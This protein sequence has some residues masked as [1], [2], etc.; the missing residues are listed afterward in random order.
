MAIH[1][2][3]ATSGRSA[4]RHL[5]D[6]RLE[7][8]E[9]FDVIDPATGAPFATAPA[10]TRDQLD[11][12]VA[13]AR[14]AQP[15]WAKAGWATRAA[16][17]CAFADAI[18]AEAGELERLLVREQG[19][20][21]A[22]ARMEITRTVAILRYV[23]G[24]TLGPEVLRDDERGRAE[25][26]W[27][28][29][30][31]VGAIT[32][33]NAPVV[34]AAPKIA[35]ALIAG[36][37]LIL[38]PSPYTPLTTLRLAEIAQK[39]FPPGVLNVLAGGDA[40]GRWMTEHPGI[41]KITF[42]GSVATGKKVMASAA[43]TLK[44]L[45]LELG[46]NDAAI[47]L[48]DADVD[49][50]APKLFQAAFVNSGQ[51]C[52]AVK[53]V[54]VHDRLYEPM[55]QALA[56]RARDAVVGSGLDPQTTLGPVQ[57]RMQYERVLG[58]LEDTS[59]RAGPRF[60]TGGG[61]LDRPGYFIAPPIVADIAE[62][63][64]LVDEEAFGPALPVLRFQEIDEAITRANATHFGLGGSIWTSDVARGADL[65]GRL[66]TGVAWVNHH[67]GVGPDLPFG[68]VKESGMGRIGSEMGLK[69][70]LEPQLLVLP[71]A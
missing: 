71:P 60:V 39:L 2:G 55:V 44:R 46:G 41:D 14:G 50:V 1:N 33:W 18:A 61:A 9:P 16:S 22:G 67:V 7:H 24:M 32:P 25:L 47:V 31:V 49:A 13:A 30:G 54:Y 45:T 43:G 15:P 42:T 26:R 65:A 6:G 59:R 27:K 8:G 58:I 28:P 57:N 64:R 5:I 3:L 69:G 68:G 40:F 56:S 19:K 4:F 17:L 23:S 62:G 12:A 53:R 10:A 48:D 63:T 70:E 35:T 38:K 52:Q 21:L 29:L 37:T 20:P 66:E 36:D 51:V 34:L 11:R